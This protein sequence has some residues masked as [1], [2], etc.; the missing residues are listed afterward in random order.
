M[1]SVTLEIVIIL[2]LVAINGVLAMSEIAVVSARKARLQERAEDGDAGA[3]TALELAHEPTRFLS[4]VQIGITLVG[5]LAGAF[6]GATITT[7]IA[8]GLHRVPALAPYSEAI[9][10]AAVVLAITFL[11]L[12]FGELIPK[13]IGLSHAERIA[14]GVARPM[15]LLAAVVSPLVWVLALFTDLFLRLLRLRPSSE[16]AVTEEEVRIMIRQGTEAGVFEE[17]EEDLVES[18]F[19]LADERVEALMTPRVDIIGIP[20]N[21]TTD[22]IVRRIMHADYSYFPVYERSLDNVLGVVSAREVL[23][24]VVGDR[25]FDVRAILRQPVFVPESMRALKAVRLLRE[26]ETHVAIVLDEY[27]GLQGVITLTD[28][29][30]A[31]VGT[32]P[33][34]GG[35]GVPGA[36]EREDGSWLV[37]GSFPVDELEDLMGVER[38]SGSGE[39]YHTVGGLL[40]AHLGR[41]PDPGNTIAWQGLRLEVM[42]MDGR[43]IDKVLVGRDRET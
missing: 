32:I 20:V 25:P 4:T 38:P 35:D 12:L 39:M 30:E 16:P 31:I 18:V 14:S 3:R 19:E 24:F 7:K 21:A 2:L 42:D 11:S 17:A 13:R 29:L 40:M 26:A 10:V 5:V 43:R 36:V 22:E 8:A 28:I 15:R 27:G 34:L 41:L 6:G 33:T 1:S 9:S 23:A 37:D